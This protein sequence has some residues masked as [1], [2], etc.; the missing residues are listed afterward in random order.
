M[1]YLS[2]ETDFKLIDFAQKAQFFILDIISDIASEGNL[3]ILQKDKD[4]FSYIK[5]TED[6]IPVMIL[7]GALPW[8]AQ[9]LHS[10][11]FK[12]L[13]PTDKDVYGLGKV[14]GIAKEVVGER[15][16]PNK[17][18]QRDMLGSFVRHDLTQR[19]A[20]SETH[21]NSGHAFTK[22]LPY[23]IGKRMSD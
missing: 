23:S 6:T 4:M 15:F 17:K 19:E 2:T 1:K 13:L 18:E 7:I 9:I 3:V 5:T 21:A 14:M 8:L 22:I 11:L 20:E 10:R 16:G 12:S